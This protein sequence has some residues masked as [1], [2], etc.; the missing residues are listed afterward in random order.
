MALD[1]TDSWFSPTVRYEGYGRAEFSRPRGQ[2]K[3]AASIAFSDLGD[4]RITM[5]VAE[6][7]PEKLPHFGMIEFLH[8]GEQTVAAE[9]RVFSPGLDNNPCTLFEVE[10]QQ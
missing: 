1:P 6:F 7:D 9:G 5:E 2:M 4:S 10:T 8:G 3:G